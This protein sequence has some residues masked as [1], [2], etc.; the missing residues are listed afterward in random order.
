MKTF[1]QNLNELVKA[2]LAEQQH[3]KTETTHETNDKNIHDM[4]ESAKRQDFFQDNNAIGKKYT[5]TCT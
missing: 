4:E 2:T 5:T 1:N 3:I